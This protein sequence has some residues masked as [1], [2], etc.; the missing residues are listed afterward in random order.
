MDNRLLDATW[1]YHDGTKHSYES[2]RTNAH[3]LDWPNQPLPF[4]VYSTLE[5]LS[6][7]EV[8]YPAIRAMHAGSSLNEE[9]E[10]TAFFSPHAAGKSVMFLIALGRSVKRNAERGQ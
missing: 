2:V 5:R 6:K 1:T 7:S 10:V 9:D 8:D 3:F 4:K